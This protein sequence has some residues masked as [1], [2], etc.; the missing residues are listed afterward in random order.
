MHGEYIRG[1][2]LKIS[3]SL[4]LEGRQKFIE[5]IVDGAAY[6]M[7]LTLGQGGFQFD[8]DIEDLLEPTIGVNGFA[9]QSL[10]LG[11]AGAWPTQGTLNNQAYMESKT[12]TFAP[13]GPFSVEIQR[14]YLVDEAT[15][16][17]GNVISVSQP[18]PAPLLITD[19]TPLVERQFKY[20][21][22]L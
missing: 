22:Y 8:L 15:A 6:N 1:D 4:T 9:R 18:L 16:N 20:R 10:G 5:R 12:V 13:T 17:V 19:T 3:N 14:M 21:L 7:W 11:E 2:G